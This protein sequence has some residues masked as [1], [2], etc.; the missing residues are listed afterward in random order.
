MRAGTVVLAGLLMWTIASA[1]RS[2]SRAPEQSS[3]P[4]GA[5]FGTDTAVPAP[6][7]SALRGAC[8]DCHS[9]ETRWPWYAQVAPVSWWIVSDVDEGRAELNFSEWGALPAEKRERRAGQV[10][11]EIE[12]DAMPPKSYRRLHGDAAVSAAELLLLRRWAE[13]RD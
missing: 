12:S 9:N 11:D 13:A 5:I 4:A 3:P 1:A 6:V 8:F 10:L 2:Y 7:R